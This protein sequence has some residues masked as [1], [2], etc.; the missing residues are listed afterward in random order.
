M[1]NETSPC[2]R[3]KENLTHTVYFGFA[4]SSCVIC[5]SLFKLITI[6]RT[7]AL[8]NNINYFIASVGVSDFIFAVSI[9]IFS[10]FYLTGLGQF[11][12]GSNIFYSIILGML[13]SSIFSSALHLIIIAIDRHMYILKPF[14]YIK[15]MTPKRI[16]LL[17]IF[18]WG[19]TLLY[20][21]TPS[22]FY[23]NNTFHV[24][25][26]LLYP[27]KEYFAVV[28]AAG[29][30]VYVATF[31]CYF[32]IAC[33][34]FERKK[35]RNVR[36]QLQ[37]K[38]HIDSN[39]GTNS[40]AAMKSVKFFMSMFGIFAIFYAPATIV[41]VM[42]LLSYDVP[43]YI[44]LINL[45]F[46]YISVILTFCFYIRVNKAFCIGIKKSIIRMCPCKL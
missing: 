22:I 26:I 37:D 30:T 44:Y 42:S 29:F 43:V 45:Y 32:R 9:V 5:L 27:P 20:L 19:L 31:V 18:V 34:A 1:Y 46:A 41:T 16:C 13:Y 7:P 23:T 25:C 14:C 6:F 10:L 35:A 24:K 21:I 28:V 40:K 36:R 39:S 11:I 3:P 15:Y 4:L 33:V 12:Q 2:I 17:L 8:H 38:S